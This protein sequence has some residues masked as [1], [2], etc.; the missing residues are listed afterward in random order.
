[1]DSGNGNF[2]HLAVVTLEVV[3]LVHIPVGA[4]HILIMEAMKEVD[5]WRWLVAE[6]EVRYGRHSIAS[7]HHRSVWDAIGV[8][9]DHSTLVKDKRSSVHSLKAVR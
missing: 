1:M 6:R 4:H 3:L 2:R 7:T 5:G 8:E 9:S